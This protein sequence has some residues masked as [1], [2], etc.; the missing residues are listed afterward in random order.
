M[1]RCARLLADG[2]PLHLYQRGNNR[3]DCFIDVADRLHYLALLRELGA[4]F[5]CS[6]HAYV[7]MTNHVHLLVTP[8]EAAR[9]ARFMRSLG[10]RYVQRFN[11]RHGRSGTLW[12]GRFHSSLVQ[13]DHYFLACHRYIESNPV[14]AGMVARPGEYPW[15]S[16]RANALGAPSRILTPHPVYEA[17]AGTAHARQAAYARLFNLAASAAE[18]EAIR[19]SL[20]KGK[21]LGSAAGQ[22]S[23]SNGSVVSPSNITAPSPIEAPGA[24]EVAELDGFGAVAEVE[25]RGGAGAIDANVVHLEFARAG[26]ARAGVGEGRLDDGRVGAHAA[27]GFELAHL[28]IGQVDDRPLRSQGED[29][30]HDED[31]DGHPGSFPQPG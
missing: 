30:A 5:Q 11:R 6:V 7:L 2:L 20:K 1:P 27:R 24:V 17:L 14:R 23:S 3:C 28:G 18:E 21:P 31:A 26:L 8:A 4:H 10:Q 25:H 19:S 22:N 13:S 15:S 12:E 29:G 9:L 16:Y